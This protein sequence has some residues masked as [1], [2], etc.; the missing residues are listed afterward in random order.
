MR[1]GSRRVWRWVLITCSVVAVVVPIGLGLAHRSIEYAG[2]EASIAAVAVG[3]TSLAMQVFRDRKDARSSTPEQLD[4]AGRK[5][6]ALVKAHW[7][8]R[9]RSAG[10]GERDSFEV[11]WRVGGGSGLR[12]GSVSLTRLG[13]SEWGRMVIVGGPGSGKTTLA[14]KLAM[15]ILDGDGPVPVVLPLAGWDPASASLEAW[16]AT[17]IGEV[18]PLV[19]EDQYGPTVL[20]DLVEDRRV[21]PVLDG[22]DEMP[23]KSRDQAW[24]EINAAFQ[25][26]GRV[27]VTCQTAA[28]A[29]LRAGNVRGD[30]I[31]ISLEPVS[32][33]GIVAAF[34]RDV[35]PSDPEWD[36]FL[37]ALRSAPDAPLAE[38][39]GNP[40]MLDLARTIYR[41]D[42]T[43]PAAL[44]RMATA[45]REAV[46]HELLDTF[47][48]SAFV[49]RVRTARARRPRYDVEDA[50]RWLSWL[51]R[52][53]TV[54]FAWWRLADEVPAGLFYPLTLMLA[55]AVAVVVDV[56]L[57]VVIGVLTGT[58]IDFGAGLVRAAV[59]YG[60]VA[61]FAYRLRGAPRLTYI[62]FRGRWRLL[63]T[64]LAR[65]V[66]DGLA[67][68]LLSGVAAGVVVWFA[69][70]LLG[71]VLVGLV[72]GLTVGV[73]V[74]LVAGV[75]DWLSNPLL[76]TSPTTPDG[77]L[78]AERLRIA[79]LAPLVG[80]VTGVLIASLAWVLLASESPPGDVLAVAMILGLMASTAVVARST[81]WR[82]R[83]ACLWLAARGRLPWRLMSFLRHCHE[84][85]ILRQAGATYEFRHR[86]V[87]DRLAGAADPRRGKI[88]RF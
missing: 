54:R 23:V 82:F 75:E 57:Q 80:L 31:V 53:N 39:L 44:L 30:H 60:A 18:H 7:R 26:S 43:G 19:A 37:A 22:L 81:W 17:E 64:E 29:A 71:G 16:I 52:R 38:T 34:E 51:A 69:V 5:L 8:E 63:P 25:G 48:T 49:G 72:F 58:S 35:R 65:H 11:P 59:I 67:A 84:N 70:N 33:S 15:A 20:S 21:L 79:A 9:L 13:R 78:R 27:V 50:R 77:A 62:A 73:A 6:R 1:R 87:G 10:A 32:P 12:S 66:P 46:E 40:F 4:S 74:T 83:L 85:G 3:L 76:V 86:F 2:W 61:V 28:F 88:R 47:L 36:G 55:G 24:T 45:D 42:P 14:A 56:V 41:D 68:C